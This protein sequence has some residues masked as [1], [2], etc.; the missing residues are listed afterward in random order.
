MFGGIDIAVGKLSVYTAAAGVDPAR[1]IPVALDVGTDNRG[2]L[3]DPLYLGNRHGRVRGARYDA[4][5]DAFVRTTTRRFPGA[6]LHWEGSLVIGGG[7]MQTRVLPRF[8]SLHEP[9]STVTGGGHVGIMG[10]FYGRRIDWLSV[11]WGVRTWIFVIFEMCAS[12][13]GVSAREI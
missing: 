10:R 1:G 7:A 6:L 12:K 5:I 3:C 9:F 11:N 4:F 8:A 2:L 13:N